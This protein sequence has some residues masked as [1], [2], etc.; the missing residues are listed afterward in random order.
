M[1]LVTAIVHNED[2]GTV[3]ALFEKEGVPRHAFQLVGRIP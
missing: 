3:D 2:A 1:K